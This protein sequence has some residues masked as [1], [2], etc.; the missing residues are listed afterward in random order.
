MEKILNTLKALIGTLNDVSMQV[1]AIIILV[2]GAVLVLAHQA[3]H[4][5]MVVGGGLT[6]LQ[7]KQEQK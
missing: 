3:E 7:H 5:S 4:G 1:W 2:I 6:L